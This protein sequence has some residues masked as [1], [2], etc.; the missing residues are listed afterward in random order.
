MLKLK[1]QHQIARKKPGA[2][3][4][5]KRKKKTYY[6]MRNSCTVKILKTDYEIYIYV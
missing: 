4:T 3:I 1:E 2:E 5:K 6:T